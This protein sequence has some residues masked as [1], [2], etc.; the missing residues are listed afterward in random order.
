M[1]VAPV[2][3]TPDLP[4]FLAPCAVEMVSKPNFFGG[5]A[6]TPAPAPAVGQGLL[7][8]PVTIAPGDGRGAAAAKLAMA[9]QQLVR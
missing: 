1:R 8:Q 6:P 4:P 7:P 2:P 3:A 5:P 9:W